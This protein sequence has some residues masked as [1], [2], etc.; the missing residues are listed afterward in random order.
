MKLPLMNDY[1]RHKVEERMLEAKGYNIVR[2]PV[3]MGPSF[4]IGKN[5]FMM[6]SCPICEQ[7]NQWNSLRIHGVQY[8][9]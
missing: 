2:L 4:V 8:R 6:I 1:A 5:I 7:E 3:M 9:F